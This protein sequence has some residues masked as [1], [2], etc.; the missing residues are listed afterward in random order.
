E[1]EAQMHGTDVVDFDDGAGVK[2]KVVLPVIPGWDV[3]NG[4]SFRYP[5]KQPVPDDQNTRSGLSEQ[6]DPL[7][8]KTD[9]RSEYSLDLRFVVVG[10]QTRHCVDPYCPGAMVGHSASNSSVPVSSEELKPLK[11]EV[12]KVPAD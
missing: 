10:E 9:F 3:W 11:P 4:A 12:G 2:C 1:I 7:S 5:T 6:T 8:G